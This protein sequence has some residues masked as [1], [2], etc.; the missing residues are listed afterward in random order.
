MIYLLG[1]YVWLYVH[2]PFEVWP[3]LGPLQIERIY[4]LIL[5]LVWLVHPGK[6]F[7]SNRI[8]FALALS[9]AALVASWLLSSYAGFPGCAEVV[10]NYA[11]V[12]VFYVLMVTSVRDEKNLRLLLLF[13]L[14]SVG[15]YA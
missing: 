5:V 3:A 2:R 8:H 14:G 11:K 13:F 10:E 15:L 7:V 4:M 12:A 9:T 1:G 6:G